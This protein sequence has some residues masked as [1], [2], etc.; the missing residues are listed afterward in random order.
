MSTTIQDHI[1]FVIS[2]VFVGYLFVISEFIATA[3]YFGD[4]RYSLVFHLYL[5][6]PTL[7]GFLIFLSLIIIILC[8]CC[9]KKCNWKKADG[10]KLL[11][12]I[13]SIGMVLFLFHIYYYG[14]PIFLLLLV[15]P[16]KVITVVAYLT[17][18]VFVTIII[19]SISIHQ[20]IVY[21]INYHKLDYCRCIILIVNAI[22]VLV[23]PVLVFVLVILFLY[24]LVLGEASAISTGPYTV[25]SLIPTAA[26]SAAS[27]LVKNKVFVNSNVDINKKEDKKESNQENEDKRKSATNDS[28]ALTLVNEDTPLNDQKMGSY[29][30]I[31]SN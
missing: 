31:N 7:I 14:L 21:V 22:F 13:F 4:N 3:V 24:I 29:G 20:I 26:I 19:S 11:S 28:G 2:A 12:L 17:T 30:A 6:I 10:R 9:Y 27:W 8:V 16:T 18:F 1:D 15:Y 5:W 23:Y 25:L